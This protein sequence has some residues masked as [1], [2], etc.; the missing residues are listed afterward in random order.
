MFELG[1]WVR[2][3]FENWVLGCENILKIGRL[4]R[5]C[6][7]NWASGC[8]NVFKIGRLGAKICLKFGVWDPRTRI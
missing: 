8:E 7:E 3:C 2:K 1:R 6:F 4:V 5:I